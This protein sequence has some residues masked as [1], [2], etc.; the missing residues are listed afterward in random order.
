MLFAFYG[1][2]SF[3][4]HDRGLKLEQAFLSS[5]FMNINFDAVWLNLGVIRQH[6]SNIKFSK[7]V[8]YVEFFSA[9][10]T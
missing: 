9:V 1:W 2:P 5:E 4:I 7:V 10:L 3:Q 8:L 6:K